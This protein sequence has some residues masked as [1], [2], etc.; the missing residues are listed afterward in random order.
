M[1]NVLSQ[2]P[3]S[4]ICHLFDRFW[5]NAVWLVLQ[6]FL[7]H[8]SNEYHC[9]LWLRF[10]LYV[11]LP[12]ATPMLVTLATDNAEMVVIGSMLPMPVNLVLRVSPDLK[13]RATPHPMPLAK[14]DLDF[15]RAFL[16]PMSKLM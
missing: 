3:M 9:V 5:R 4:D 7:Q 15:V 12:A 1:A 2:P 10:K 6:K 14:S 13:L 8:I 11:T 16:E